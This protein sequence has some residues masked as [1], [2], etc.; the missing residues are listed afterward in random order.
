MHVPPENDRPGQPREHEGSRIG[1]CAD[2]RFIRV[3]QSA[4]GSKFYFCE[5][6]ATDPTFPKY[7]RLPV[8]LC[9]GYEEK[10]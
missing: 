4:R 7:P 6:S 5:R 2:C 3:V 8:L 10:I 1:L 9:R